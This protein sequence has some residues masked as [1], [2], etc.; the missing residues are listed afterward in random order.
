[1][2]PVEI[3]KSVWEQMAVVVL[4]M[5]LAWVM[6]RE[7]AKALEK[8]SDSYSK[9]LEA[10]NVQWQKYFDAKNEKNDVVS[11]EMLDK[12]AALTAEIAKMVE[13]QDAHDNMTRSALDRME[14][15]RSR[16]MEAK[17]KEKAGRK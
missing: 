4:F 10:S 13:S 17:M 3:P 6:L 1:M 7:F 16:L 14:Q 2:L 8:I 12:I 15:K 9:Q 11:N 5:I